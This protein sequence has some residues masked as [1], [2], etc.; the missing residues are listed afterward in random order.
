[1]NALA[2]S[3]ARGLR[4]G[5]ESL[6]R[7]VAWALLA[8]AGAVLLPGRMLCALAGSNRIIVPVPSPRR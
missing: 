1:M 7:N 6:S 8:L 3:H 2:A 5:H 4:S